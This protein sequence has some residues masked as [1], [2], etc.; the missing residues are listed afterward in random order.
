MVNKM[1]ADGN[2]AI[3]LSELFIMMSRKKKSK[4]QVAK[5]ESMGIHDRERNGPKSTELHRISTT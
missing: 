3:E 2:Q 1:E 4:M 5:K